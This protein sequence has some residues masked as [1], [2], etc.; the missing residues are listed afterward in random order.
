MLNQNSKPSL[1]TTKPPTSNKTADLKPGTEADDRYEKLVAQS[2]QG[3]I[4]C[5]RWWMKAVAPGNW[6]ILS[7]EKG[8]SLT[9]AWPLVTAESRHGLT[10]TMPPLTQKLGILFAPTQSKYAESLSSQHDLIG[11]LIDQLPPTAEFRHHFHERFTNWL[12]FYWKGYAQSTRY[13]YILD[14]IGDHDATWQEM[15]TNARTTIRKAEKSGLI[16]TDD[17]PLDQFIDLNRMVFHRQG[18]TMP[19]PDQTIIRL[20]EACRQRDKRKIFAATDSQNRVH[21][22]LYLVWDNET[23]YYLMAGSDPELRR[24][25]AMYLLQWEAIRF[26]STV[27]KRYDFEGSMMH[28]VET[29]F[30]SLG[31]RQHPYFVITKKPELTTRRLIEIGA[32]R[33]WRSLTGLARR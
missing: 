4:Y 1:E 17:F 19:V 8:D 9:T 10:V 32:S 12:P 13:T 23:A 6:R 26:A 27:A 14:N 22:A 31:G 11:Q 16:V 21:A 33:A 2:P 15:R 30:R 24:S 29:A 7:I 28:Q 5:Q 3:S 25:G 20:D 18:K